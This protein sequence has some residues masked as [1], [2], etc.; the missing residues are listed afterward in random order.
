LDPYK[1]REDFP[2]LKRE[3]NGNPLI[4]FDN[5]ATTQKPRQ[6][7][8]AIRDFY[9]NY[10]ANVHRAVHTISLEATEL[11]EKASETIS[12]FIG[13]KRPFGD[14]LCQRDN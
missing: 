14:R 9:E 13:A 11:Y 12:A 5:A 6:V 3:V 2:I 8:Q 1:I 4:Y 7:I 10:N